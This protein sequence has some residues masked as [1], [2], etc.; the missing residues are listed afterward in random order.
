MKEMTVGV[1]VFAQLKFFEVLVFVITVHFS[2]ENVRTSISFGHHMYNCKCTVNIPIKSRTHYF[3][4]SVTECIFL[5][6]CAFSK[7]KVFLFW[8]FTLS[9][10]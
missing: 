8:S 10:N 5:N 4:R 9:V 2:F 1:N 7:T 6:S 3:L